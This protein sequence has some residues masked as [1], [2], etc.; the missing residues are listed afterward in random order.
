MTRTADRLGIERSHP[1]RK[2]KAY[3]MAGAA[4]VPLYGTAS[5]LSAASNTT[6]SSPATRRL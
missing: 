6:A 1:Y 4:G 2:L 5:H 3:K